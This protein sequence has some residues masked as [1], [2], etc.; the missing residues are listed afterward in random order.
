MEEKKSQGLN[1]QAAG[2][3]TDEALDQIAGGNTAYD[4][5][6]LQ[7]KCP[8]CSKTYDVARYLL[9]GFN[10]KHKKNCPRFSHGPQS[11]YTESTKVVEP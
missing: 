9:E 3:V 8:A 4:T 2:E 1:A 11:P 7:W 6:L 10:A 5:E